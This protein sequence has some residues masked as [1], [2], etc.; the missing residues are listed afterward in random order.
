MRLLRFPSAIVAML[1]S[2]EHVRP[3]AELCRSASLRW[4]LSSLSLASLAAT[5]YLASEWLFFVT[6]PSPTAALPFA[7]QVTVLLKSPAPFLLPLFVAQVTASLLSLPAFPRFR[8]V[9]LI[10]ASVIGGFLLLMLI[11]NFTATMLGYGIVRSGEVMRVVYAALLPVLSAAAGWKLDAWIG[12]VSSRRLGAPVS[13]MISVGLLVLPR[14]ARTETLPVLPDATV[15]PAME[16]DVDDS[17]RPNIV[18]LG[19]DGVDAD[20]TS[21][22]GYERQTTPFLQSLRDDTLFFENA[23]SN[24]ART[25]GSLVTLLTGRLPFT[26][27]VTFPPTLLQGADGDRTLPMLLK[28]LGYTTL[29]L[30][31]RHYADAEDTNVR[32]FD[33]A[34]Y[35]W[36]QLADTSRGRD[37]AGNDETDVFRR[38]VAERIDERLGRLFGTDPV[39]DGFAHVEGRQIVPQWR[40]ER[41]V[42][43]MVEYFRHAPEP[44]FVHLHLLDTHCCF[45]KPDR[46]HFTDGES[47]AIDARDSQVRETDDNVRRL[48]EALVATGKLERTIVVISSDHASEWKTT[49]PVPLM[50]RFPNRHIRGHISP[51]VQ[52]ADV[53]P[54]MLDYLGAEVPSWMDGQSLLD[55]ET[56]SASR[57]IFGVSDVQATTGPSGR[58]FL[59]DGAS[60]NFGA[61]ALMMIAGTHVFE[62]N[63]PTGQLTSRP[64]DDDLASTPPP[65]SETE[66]RRLMLDRARTAGFEVDAPDLVAAGV[67]PSPTSH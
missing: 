52:I 19:I 16:R 28:G 15:L 24:V 40:D 21:A 54:T 50:I 30:G 66:A 67:V 49:K 10:P 42:K 12:K 4:F 33:A 45:W 11:D 41:R 43:T 6:K 46:F 7:S 3:R 51:N 37:A 47:A 59:R 57:L 1:R 64:V 44:W 63:L 65:M 55:P 23:F 18:F 5:V 20:I 26:T 17:N 35:R 9:A 34:N 31:M 62:L 48:F 25:H 22:Y 29:Q 61:S 2:S 39:A 13:V 60:R 53:A 38:A 27:H 32:G 8:V 58:H 36:Q 56:I 14:L